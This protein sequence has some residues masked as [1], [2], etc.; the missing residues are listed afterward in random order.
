MAQSSRSAKRYAKAVYLL[1]RQKREEA[2]WDA[3]LET[4]SALLA[5]PDVARTLTHPKLG[6]PGKWKIFE[7]LVGEQGVVLRPETVNLL[8]LLIQNQKID[9]LPDLLRE[10]QALWEAARGLL[11]VRLVTAI[12]LTDPEKT[13]L[14]ETLTRSL[15]KEIRLLDVVDPGILGGA[16]LRIGDRMIDG[17][18]RT[19]IERLRESMIA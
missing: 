14:R 5:V 4:A 18:L 12:P 2:L 7:A 11:P 13:A 16:I 3:E 1:A 10:Y 6:T 17:S 9:I 8:K 19:R 15:G